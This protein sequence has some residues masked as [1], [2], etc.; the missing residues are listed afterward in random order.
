[1]TFFNINIFH[2]C[3]AELPNSVTTSIKVKQIPRA[4]KALFLLAKNIFTSFI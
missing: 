1:M 3:N 4:E 2:L